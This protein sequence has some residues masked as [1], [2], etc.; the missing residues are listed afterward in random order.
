MLLHPFSR[1]LS[2]KVGTGCGRALPSN[3][4]Y[5]GFKGFTPRGMQPHPQVGV[6][7]VRVV[8]NYDTSFVPLTFVTTMKLLRN[9]RVRRKREHQN[10][11]KSLKSVPFFAC[12]LPC[13]ERLNHKFVKNRVKHPSIQRFHTI[14]SPSSPF[15]GTL[16]E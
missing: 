15:R 14:S 6:R 4:G 2:S 5:L 12:I 7:V 11:N 8:R 13:F 1:G 16:N 10:V 3:M 9:F